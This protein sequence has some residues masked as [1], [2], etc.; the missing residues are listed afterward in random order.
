MTTGQD[1]KDE[2][3]ISL[4]I[5]AEARDSGLQGSFYRRTH[6]CTGPSRTTKTLARI[7]TSIIR[8]TLRCARAGAKN[9]QRRRYEERVYTGGSPGPEVRLMY[10]M[11][12]CALLHSAPKL[13]FA[14]LSGVEDL[15][16]IAHHRMLSGVSR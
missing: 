8:R 1:S 14:V 16:A 2:A 3:K 4:A 7:A 11:A 5:F 13:D 9:R 12:C 10:S 6:E 15:T